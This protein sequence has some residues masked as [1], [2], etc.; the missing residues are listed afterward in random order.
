MTVEHLLEQAK[1][2]APQLVRWRRDLHRHPEIGFE[3]VRTANVVAEHLHGLG[4]QVAEGIGR[5]GVVGLLEGT[6]PGPTIALRAD[7]DA[8]PIQDA[9]SVDYGSGVAGKAH[10]CGHDAHTTMLMGAAQL[11]RDMGPPAR[12]NIKF[13]FQP[14]EEGLA[15][16]AAMIADG[17]L[18]RPRVDAIVGLHVYPGL[19]TGSFAMVKG[20]AHASVDDFVI[21]IHGQGGHAAR[22][23]EA[24]DAIAVAGQVITGL[25]QVVSRMIDPLETAVLTIGK[26]SGGYMGSSIAPEVVLHGTVRTLAPHVR[27]RMPQLVERALDHLTAAFGASHTLDYHHN[28]PVVTND[29]A[30]IDLMARATERLVGGKPWSAMT[31]STGGEDFAFYTE[32]IP[33]AFIRLGTSSGSAETSYPLH[34]PMF[35]LDEQALPIG[36]A[37]LATAALEYLNPKKGDD[38]Q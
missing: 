1:R 31:P 33:G 38:T 35:D 17:V 27:E 4:L 37:L 13:I 5:T 19:R 28:Y 12:G 21:R 34:H 30:M 18:D 23:H 10:L 20:V 3:E 22:P 11:L 26:I 9:K 7:M 15:G 36:S 6:S 14:A 29:G 2:L 32:R 8:L 16:A 25:Q 24:I